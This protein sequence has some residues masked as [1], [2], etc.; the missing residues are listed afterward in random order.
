M[1]FIRPISNSF[2][3]CHNLKGIKLV[4]R[5][6]SGLSHLREHKFK[7][8]FQDSL[9]PICR[10]GADVES[11]VHYLPHCPLFSKRKAYPLEHCWEYCYSWHLVIVF[12][13]Y[14]CIW[15]LMLY[16][17]TK[18][19]FNTLISMVNYWTK[20]QK[21]KSHFKREKSETDKLYFRVHQCYRLDAL[22]FLVYMNDLADD[23]TLLSYLR[24]TY[25]NLS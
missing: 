1:Q 10:C 23:I 9:N 3:N 5:L 17:Y 24:I 4:T 12:L 2:L 21:E 8:S 16:I 20:R 11:C 15:K 13:S 14:N 6:R 22:L 7:H 19:S 25:F 18:K